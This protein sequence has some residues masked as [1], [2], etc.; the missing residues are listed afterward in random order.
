M[1]NLFRSKKARERDERRDRRKAFRQAENALDYVKE[2]QRSLEREADTQWTAAREATKAGEKEKTRRALTS[3]RGTQVMLTR[4][5]QKRWVFEQ[6][7]NKMEMARTD[8]EFTA[9]LNRV[10]LVTKVD[11]EA[12]ADV[13]EASQ[14]LL[15][16]Q[17]DSDRF[18]ERLYEKES[19]GAASKLEEHFPSMDELDKQLEEEAALE[20]GSGQ[21]GAESALNERL[22]A[23]QDR[24][25]KLLDQGKS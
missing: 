17:A 5:E 20:V 24:V 4:I 6:Y 7:L 1:S 12:T 18:W 25:N 23:S 9:A 13:F 2:R 14:E 10:N 3:Y 22:Q 19:G 21:V 11:P 15:G 8:Q 16:E